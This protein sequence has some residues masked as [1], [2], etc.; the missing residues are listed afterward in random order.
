MNLQYVLPLFIVILC[1]VGYHLLSKSLPN[2]INPFIGLSVTYAIALI[3][4]ILLFFFTKDSLFTSQKIY[5]NVYNLLLGIIIIGVEGGYILM[6]RAGWEVGK[7]S[8][9]SNIILA[10][11]LLMIGAI[12]FQEILTLQKLIGIGL[13]LLGIILLK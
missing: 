11:L 2:H 4:S 1:N 6:Y 13:C 12:W 10:I 5:I 3:G 8:L 9:Y 7:A